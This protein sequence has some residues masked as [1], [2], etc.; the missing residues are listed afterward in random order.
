MTR[1]SHA[2]SNTQT[3]ALVL[4]IAVVLASMAS[5]S[6]ASAADPNPWICNEVFTGP[7]DVCPECRATF[8]AAYDASE[9]AVPRLVINE[10]EESFVLCSTEAV[11]MTGTYVLFSGP[12]PQT[13]PTL[14]ESTAVQLDPIDALLPGASLVTS[15]IVSSYEVDDCS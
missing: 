9:A 11:L 12:P 14:Q 10:G 6:R 15:F 5:L 3:K 7:P 8:S 4:S 13:T 1:S 2:Q